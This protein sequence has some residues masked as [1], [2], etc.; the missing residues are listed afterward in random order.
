MLIYIYWCL[1]EFRL[2]CVNSPCVSL[3]YS[4]VDIYCLSISNNRESNIYW[5]QGGVYMQ[6]VRYWFHN[7]IMLYVFTCSCYFWYISRIHALDLVLLFFV[8]RTFG[9]LYWIKSF[10]I[11][12]LRERLLGILLLRMWQIVTKLVKIESKY[13]YITKLKIDKGQ[14]DR[15]DR[16]DDLTK[17]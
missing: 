10:F 1:L 7:V 12:L 5:V 4:S 17:L 11:K 6:R 13:L 15:Y 9:V 2:I 14:Y 16:Y 8:Y 3:I